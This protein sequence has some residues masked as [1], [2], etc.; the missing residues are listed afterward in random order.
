MNNNIILN[1]TNDIDCVYLL[2]DKSNQQY[3]KF[4]SDKIGKEFKT[5]SELCKKYCFENGP[6]N[7]KS[8]SKQQ[9]KDFII[10][11]I[12]EY[13]ISSLECVNQIIDD[14]DSFFDIGIPDFYIDI[15]QSLNF[16]KKFNGFQKFTLTGDCIKQIPIDN[17]KKIDIVLW[18]D[19][20]ENFNNQNIESELPKVIKNIETNFYLYTEGFEKIS[21]VIYPQLDA[22]NGILYK[23]NYFDMQVRGLQLG[24]QIKEPQIQETQTIE[25]DN[26]EKPIKEK[27]QSK[28][29]W[30]MVAESW[31]KASQFMDAASSRGLISTVL[32]YTGIDNKQGERVSDEIYN[33]RRDSCFGS[34]E[35]DIK[36]CQFLSKD[37][38][39]MYFCK[40][41]G[42]GT[43]KLAV[44]NP[45]EENGYSKL[46]YP[47]LECP[48]AKPGFSNHIN[49]N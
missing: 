35:K 18:F 42:C 45:T 6:C 32:D 12:K 37:V 15:I 9:E 47:N 8:I 1:E 10:K 23:S 3:C 13:D 7:N 29:G 17:L 46:H 40:A 41:C 33:L 30:G 5:C 16:L 34:V 22:E 4:L 27:T 49:N 44:L 25:I 38:D 20:I 26:F 14:Y 11:S 24:I 2:K 21:D 39:D 43:N 36:P 31:H 19:S 48:L 28:L